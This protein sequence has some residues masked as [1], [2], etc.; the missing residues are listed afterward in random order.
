MKP[1]LISRA[2]TDVEAVRGSATH[3]ASCND[4]F[5]APLSSCRTA[6]THALS[7]E[8]DLKSKRVRDVVVV[9]REKQRAA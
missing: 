2:D 8:A 9:S 3:T 6:K 1:S 5:S 7:P 4:V